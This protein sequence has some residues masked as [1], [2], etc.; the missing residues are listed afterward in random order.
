LS[1]L[2]H[3]VGLRGSSKKGVY[4]KKALCSVKSCPLKNLVAV[5]QEIYLFAFVK[6]LF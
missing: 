5:A 6:S 1:D 4:S 2:I 3:N